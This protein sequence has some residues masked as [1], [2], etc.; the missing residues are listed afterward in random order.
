M[1]EDTL[2]NTRL[3]GTV[4]E[5]IEGR[6]AGNVLVVGDDILL[7]N[8]TAAGVLADK[9]CVDDVCCSRLQKWYIP[10]ALSILQ[11]GD[12]ISD[13]VW[14]TRQL[15]PCDKLKIPEAAEELR[16]PEKQCAFATRLHCGKKGA[17]LG[18]WHVRQSWPWVRTLEAF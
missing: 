13:H 16:D 10:G 7:E 14:K 17:Y 4:E 3:E 6:A 5:R 9:L 12:G 2:L 1:L 18:S 11:G 8:G 15:V